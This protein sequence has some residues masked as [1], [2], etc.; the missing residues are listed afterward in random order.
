VYT[1]ARS[2]FE[3]TPQLAL[4]SSADSVIAMDVRRSLVVPVAARDAQFSALNTFAAAVG[5]NWSVGQSVVITSKGSGNGFDCSAAGGAYIVASISSGAVTLTGSRSVASTD[6]TVSAEV[7]NDC[8]IARPSRLTTTAE[9]VARDAD[10]QS[11]ATFAAVAGENWIQGQ[12]VI[13]VDKAS[14]GAQFSCTGAGNYHVVAVSATVPALVSLTGVVATSQIV[15]SEVNND[16]Q[17]SRAQD[18]TKAQAI[19]PRDATFGAAFAFIGVAGE[20]WK[21]GQPVSVL[22]KGTLGANYDCAAAA[23]AYFTVSS[24]QSAHSPLVVVQG[25][26][27]TTNRNVGSEKNNDC[28]I[29][30]APE[31]TAVPSVM[32]VSIN[33][34]SVFSLAAQN[35]KPVGHTCLAIDPTIALD[36]THCASFSSVESGQCTATGRCKYI[37]AVVGDTVVTESCTAADTNNAAHVTYCATISTNVAATCAVTGSLGEQCVYTPPAIADV[38]GSITSVAHLSLQGTDGGDVRARTLSVETNR[39][40]NL[41]LL[42]DSNKGRVTM[43]AGEYGHSRVVMAETGTGTNLDFYQQNF[44]ELRAEHLDSSHCGLERA[45]SDCLSVLFSPACTDGVPSGLGSNTCAGAKAILAAQSPPQTCTSDLTSLGIGITSLS[46]IC[47]VTCGACPDGSTKMTISTGSFERVPLDGSTVSSSQYSSF[48]ASKAFDGD[49]TTWWDGCCISQPQWI[50]YVYT[51]ARSTVGYALQTG[52]PAADAWSSTR[53]CTAKPASTATCG[54]PVDGATEC[55]DNVE[56]CVFTP[57]PSGTQGSCALSN[58][59]ACTAALAM[60][61]DGSACVQVYKCIYAKQPVGPAPLHV[62]AGAVGSLKPG[63]PTS[64]NFQG[65]NDPG[66]AWTTIDTRTNQPM[67]PELTYFT[68]TNNDKYKEF[69]WQFLTKSGGVDSQGQAIATDGVVVREARLME[70][71][72][73]PVVQVDGMKAGT[74]CQIDEC[75]ALGTFKLCCQQDT[76]SCTPLVSSCACTTTLSVSSAATLGNNVSDSV[77]LNG[78]VA[79]TR[80]LTIDAADWPIVDEYTLVLPSSAD[81]IAPR[82]VVF[83]ADNTFAAATGEVWKKG[84]PVIVTA[85]GSGGNNDCAAAGAGTYIVRAVSPAS[86]PVVTLTV[87]QPILATVDT[88]SSKVNNDCRVSRDSRAPQSMTLAFSGNHPGEVLTAF[89]NVSTLSQTG[90]LA[91]GSMASG[92]GNITLGSDISSNSMVCAGNTT[93]QGNARLGHNATILALPASSFS[94]NGQVITIIDTTPSASEILTGPGLLHSTIAAGQTLKFVHKSG[95]SLCTERGTTVTISLVAAPSLTVTGT[96]GSASTCDVERVAV[97]SISNIVLGSSTAFAT[98]APSRTGVDTTDTQLRFN[99]RLNEHLKLANRETRMTFPNAADPSKVLT[100][101]FYGFFYD[102]YY[103][104]LPG[105]RPMKLPDIPHAGHMAHRAAMPTLS[106]GGDLFVTKYDGPPHASVPE[107]QGTCSD[108]RASTS[109]SCAALATPGTWSVTS[110]NRGDVDNVGVVY[111]DGSVGVITVPQAYLA[112]NPL[113]PGGALEIHMLNSV[114]SHFIKSS[115][116]ILATLADPGNGGWPIVA[117]AKVDSSDGGA[118]IV[119]RNLHQAAYGGIA[120]FGTVTSDSTNALKIAFAAITPSE[121][122]VA[123]KPW[124]RKSNANAATGLDNCAPNPCQNCGVCRE[125][126]TSVVAPGQTETAQHEFSFRC[127]CQ[128]GFGGA[129]CEICLADVAAISP[130]AASFTADNTFAVAVSATTGFP[131]E[132]WVKSQSVRVTHANTGGNCAAAGTY[133]VAHVCGR[134]TISTECVE[135]TSPGTDPVKIVLDPGSTG[136][137]LSNGIYSAGGTGSITRSSASVN[138]D[139]LVERL[140]VTS[141]CPACGVG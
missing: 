102:A 80:T 103:G 88:V 93:A 87:S 65:R 120:P 47:P 69:R 13:V 27:L 97:T 126:Y 62:G 42:S 123:T 6:L 91:S 118:V 67:L 110:A 100:A 131:T 37:P 133:T 30:R 137:T 64:W 85:K 53:T 130:R 119:V 121:D 114:G 48:S 122:L 78:H 95:S 21:P 26:V 29:Y 98:A 40:A 59:V 2:G 139:C 33:S 99:G 4:N 82:D 128:A 106:G 138:D 51:S 115:S 71:A 43:K 39:G 54:Q 94:V 108:P 96:V 75:A 136:Y 58:Q 57:P 17:V 70:S 31:T 140:A 23:G 32:A 125:D 124:L 3:G 113:N 132:D 28:K 101:I 92:F 25:T 117:S 73:L 36:V 55:P 77:V 89:S 38:R 141:S 15:G 107:S 81:A 44:F 112:A 50:S 46:S 72:N 66:G 5:E 56:H 74:A 105:L 111:L 1:P 14:A 19:V 83:T 52:Y 61:A 20:E 10:F 68:F 76:C 24:V 86:V 116:A 34:R 79:D 22:S 84:Q 7:N 18:G 35:Q 127:E 49:N 63:Y 45:N 90:A 16:C 135:I 9:I 12:T 129:L 134:S 41:Q 104:V 109:V 11:A 8:R 60:D